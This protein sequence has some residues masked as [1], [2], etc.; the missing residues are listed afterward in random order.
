MPGRIRRMRVAGLAAGALCMVALA[1]CG[2]GSSGDQSTASGTGGAAEGQSSGTNSS[3]APV[4]IAVVSLKLPGSDLLTG[5]TAGAQAALKTIK[6][7]GG[8]GGREV[9]LATCNSMLQAAT[10][11]TCAHKTIAQHPV[12]MFGC[13]PSW[14]QAG[15]PVYSKSGI[16][17]FI[18]MNTEQDFA[19]P[20]NYGLAPGGWGIPGAM[21]KFAC[22][23]S[24]VKRVAFFT[25]DLPNY[26]PEAENIGQMLKRCGKSLE[27]FTYPATAT[28]VAPYVLKA[29]DFKP[30]F[31][32]L[33]PLAGPSVIKIY[34]QF[35]QQGVSASH[36]ILLGAAA[37]YETLHGGGAAMNGTYVSGQNASWDDTSNPDVSAYLRAMKGSPVDPREENVETGYSVVMFLYEAAKKIGFDR[38][39]SAS[40]AKFLEDKANNGFHIP[41]SRSLVIPGPE[42][43]AKMRQPSAQ[44][45]Q[46]QDGKLSVVTKGTND[47]WINGY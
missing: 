5:Y 16:P 12:A 10:T 14:T 28:D 18:C 19:S 47:G 15:A 30:D 36:V 2:G 9:S 44:I 1:A 41:L 32:L 13:E 39:N 45:M 11:A 43:F 26:V 38:F 37:S 22:G 46:W 33:D 8:F 29:A 21:A 7:Q 31:V 34:Q 4:T 27:H 3:K 20:T 40:L 24:D 25:V 35:A 42:G 17:S 23:Q 6:A